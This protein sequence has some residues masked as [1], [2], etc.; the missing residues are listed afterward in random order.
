MVAVAVAINFASAAEAA[1]KKFGYGAAEA[2]PLQ[3]IAFKP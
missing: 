1:R 3:S 2:A